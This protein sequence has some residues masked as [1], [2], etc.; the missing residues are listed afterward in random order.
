VTRGIVP[1]LASLRVGYVGTV[2][3][4][5]LARTRASC[6]SK[7][8]CTGGQFSTRRTNM[9]GTCGSR[10]VKDTRC[11]GLTPGIRHRA[12]SG[13][14][15]RAYS[16]ALSALSSTAT[17]RGCIRS[18]WY[19]YVLVPPSQMTGELPSCCTVLRTPHASGQLCTSSTWRC[20]ADFP[21][22]GRLTAN[23][24]CDNSTRTLS[25]STSSSCT[26]SEV[27]FVGTVRKNH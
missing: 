14:R 12:Y 20:R 11:S 17:Q 10:R 18:K 8:G 16:D 26:G 1:A 15:H 6:R 5:P 21:C 4:L 13:I 3:N 25:T 19:S 24:P 9:T 7:C 27:G 2:K 22:A 23:N